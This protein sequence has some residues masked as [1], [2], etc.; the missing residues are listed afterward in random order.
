MKNNK[1]MTLV[2]VILSISLIALIGAVFIPFFNY[3]LFVIDEGRKM[4]KETFKAQQD[5]E[6]SIEIAKMNKEEQYDSRFFKTNYELF[7]KKIKG[8]LITQPAF[9]DNNLRV[10]IPN[11]VDIAEKLPIVKADSVELNPV[12]PLYPYNGVKLNGKHEIDN[13]NKEYLFMELKRWYASN[14]GFDGYVPNEINNEN[15]GLFG[16]RYPIFP[17]DYVQIDNDSN[18]LG[19]LERFVGRHIVYSVTPID[20]LGKF[21]IEVNSRPVYIM[22]PPILENLSYHLDPYTLRDENGI[23]INDNIEITKWKDFSTNRVFN[24]VYSTPNKMKIS[25]LEQYGK[26]LVFNKTAFTLNYNPTDQGAY[27]IFAVYRN[28][29]SALST[30]CNIIKRRSFGDENGWEIGLYD[31]K[32]GFSI[33]QDVSQTKGIFQKSNTVAN[34]KYIITAAYSNNNMRLII[35]SNEAKEE[36]T[37]NFTY[38]VNDRNDVEL[39]IGDSDSNNNIYEIIIYNDELNEDEINIVR[40]YLAEKHGI[41]IKD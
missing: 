26:A 36:L 14:E 34:E 3:S 41:N 22:G 40:K 20:R 24:P 32:I 7:G 2:E 37:G 4:T 1:G 16:K 21:G 15:E 35:D 9:G 17:S 25:Y 10:F 11:E 27:T 29:S 6:K 13:K 18:V 33:K 19:D 28:T 5:L 12:G 30:S 31:A 38:T 39:L 23:F 8:V